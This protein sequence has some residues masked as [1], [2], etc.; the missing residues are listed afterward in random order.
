MLALR[1][2]K[3][4][5]ERLNRTLTLEV[6]VVVKTLVVEAL[7]EFFVNRVQL[8]L[9]VALQ[10]ICDLP[11]SENPVEGLSAAEFGMETPSHVIV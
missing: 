4:V 11:K 3:F 6:A 8:V 5:A 7:Q 9:L 1:P 2:V 10:D